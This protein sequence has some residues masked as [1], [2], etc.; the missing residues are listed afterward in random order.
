MMIS[1][2]TFTS[3]NKIKKLQKKPWNTI[4]FTLLKQLQQHG[5]SGKKLEILPNL[6]QEKVGKAALSANLSGT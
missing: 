5:S 3:G 4:V 1:Q 2:K 6:Q